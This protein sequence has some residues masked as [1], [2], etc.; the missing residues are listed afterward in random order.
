MSKAIIVCGFTGTGKTFLTKKIA[1]KRKNVIV[2]DIN[3]EYDL[4]ILDTSKK[5]EGGQFRYTGLDFKKFLEVIQ[6]KSGER[7]VF[8]TNIILED[9]SGFM[10]GQVG[11]Q[12][13]QIF[14]A[15][16]H[17][18]NNFFFLYHAVEMIPKDIY[19]FTNV[20]I[21][22]NT[23]ETI[24]QINKRFPAIAHGAFKVKSIYSQTR[25]LSDSNEKKY[26]YKIINLQ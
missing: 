9:C 15:K 26:P 11:S 23:N 21:Y 24:Q 19:R 8:N 3:N 16:R 13:L 5:Y 1:L 20:F 17:T 2:F 12:A 25:N 10:K 6:T 7:K 18:G 22:F 4:P 14:Q